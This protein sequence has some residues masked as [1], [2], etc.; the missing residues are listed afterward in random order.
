MGR[1]L[2]FHELFTCESRTNETR[3]VDSGTVYHNTL[4]FMK[5]SLVSILAV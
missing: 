3:L 4:Y 2:Y 5:F 1:K